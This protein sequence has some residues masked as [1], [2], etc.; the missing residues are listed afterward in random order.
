MEN[1]EAIRK[2]LVENLPGGESNIKSMFLKSTDLISVPFY[3]NTTNSVD[4]VKME[5]N[6]SVAQV[7]RAK[8]F[9]LKSKLKKKLITKNKAK[10]NDLISKKAMKGKKPKST[11]QNALNLK[12]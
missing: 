7:K 9:T 8:K 11:T 12:K 6:M 1:V 2:C 5:N 10:T 4:S 3:L